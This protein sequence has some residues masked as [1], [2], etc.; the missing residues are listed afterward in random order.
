MR[1]SDT[2]LEAVSQMHNHLKEIFRSIVNYSLEEN[3]LI[4]N[5]IFK[6]FF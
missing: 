1:L 4:I 2:H 5:L 6:I 3:M